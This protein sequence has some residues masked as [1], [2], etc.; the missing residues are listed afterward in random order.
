MQTTE[1]QVARI[2]YLESWAQVASQLSY[3]QTCTRK[4]LPTSRGHVSPTSNSMALSHV[5][6]HLPTDLDQ[7]NVLK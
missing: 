7:T 6:A 4:N 3:R 5:N 2:L 1:L